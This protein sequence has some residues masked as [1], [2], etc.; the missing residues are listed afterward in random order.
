MPVF[1]AEQL[2][3]I[4]LKIFR[5]AGASSKEAEIVSNHL[6]KANLRGHDSHGVLRIPW[7]Y[8]LIQKGYIKLGTEVEIL[9]DTAITALLDGNWGFGQVVARVAMDIAIERAKTYGLGM[10]AFFNTYHIGMLGEYSE[11]A[12]EQN[13]IGVTLCN[14][15]PNVAPYGGKTPLLSTNPLSVAIPAASGRPV[16][17]DMATSAVAAG[18]VSLAFQ[19]E[20]EVP[21]GWIIDKDGRPTTNPADLRPSLAEMPI[22][23]G[24]VER[25]SLLPL[26]GSLSGYKGYGLSLIIEILGGI[27][28]GS[29]ASDEN[30]GNGVV[31]MAINI[32]MFRPL[33]EFKEKV[34]R[35]IED[36][37]ASPKASGFSE[38]LVAGEP[39]YRE[40]E[41]RLRE[42]I[43]VEEATWKKLKQIASELDTPLEK[44][45]N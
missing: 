24:R 4:G 35:L 19:R 8:E 37:K 20:V 39:E 23:Q 40:E 3:E 26:G 45:L 28:A 17:L 1:K 36:V 21:L 31:T 6:V 38:I 18:K 27:L 10:V 43:Y 44:T 2:K 14:G 32:E 7:Y 22:P 16:L 11:M 5:A 33:N 13:L 29:G 41:H 34:S 25:G 12:A 42:G 9:K 30:R 15:S